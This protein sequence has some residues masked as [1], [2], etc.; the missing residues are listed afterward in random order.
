MTAAR[1]SFGAI[2]PSTVDPRTGEILDAD[3]GFDAN[4]V[5]AIR[6]LRVEQLPANPMPIFP[7]DGAHCAYETEAA[8]EAGFAMELLEARGELQPDSPDV[9]R[10]VH[11]FLKNVTM[12]EVGHTLGL[13]HNFRASTIFTQAQL[14]NPEFTREHG[15]SG[16]VMEYNPWNLALQDEPQGAYNMHSL[17]PYDYWAIEYGYKPIAP[18]EE[19]GEL[20]RIA[21]RSN[22]RELAFAMDDTLFYSGLDPDANTFDLSDDPLG[23]AQRRLALVRELL[24]RT[25]RREFKPGESYAVLRRNLMRSLSEARQ[26]VQHASKYVGGLTL[27]RDHAGS[28]RVPMNPVPVARQ[29]AALAMLATDVF[30][31]NSFQFP[32]ELLRRASVSIFDMENSRDLG[33]PVPTP[34]LAIDQQVLTLQ[35]LSLQQ[36]MSDTVAQRLLNNESKTPEAKE[37]LKLSELYTTLRLAIWSELRSGGDIGLVRRNLQR[38]HTALLAGPLVRP[39]ATM[40]AD[41]RSMLRAEAKAL[42]A[43][44]AAAQGRKRL[45]AE[46]RAHIAETMTTLDEALK[47]PLVRQGV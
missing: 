13:T 7:A 45:S 32:P 21:A 5:R 47:A 15:I 4:T 25:G 19:A 16:S 38:E 28:G 2:G 41:A 33:T 8:A 37:A 30:G 26:S 36:L 27:L 24:E 39:P 6:A 3:I 11:G 29:R 22:E 17:G 46:A 35:R 43:D 42:R 34:D 31:A 20:A 10:F 44:L 9:D 40:P 14:S 12:H 1:S 18:E 23:F